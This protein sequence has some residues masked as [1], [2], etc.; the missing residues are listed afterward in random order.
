MP[1]IRSLRIFNWIVA[2]SAMLTSV[3]K[4]IAVSVVC[5]F[6][7]SVL[8]AIVSPDQA[9]VAVKLDVPSTRRKNSWFNKIV[10]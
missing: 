4:G 8:V 2:I 7:P 5:P 10:P 6:V 9:K 1:L 3:P